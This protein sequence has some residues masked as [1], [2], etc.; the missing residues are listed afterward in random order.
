M[1][2]KIRSASV[3]GMEA[4]PVEI[5]VDLGPGVQDFHV[6]GMPGLAVKE[7]RRRVKSA[8]VN[9]SEQWPNRSITANLAPGDLRKEGS[10]LDLP[11]AVGVLAASGQLK[12]RNLD[13]YLMVG[14]L[15]LD[16]R[17]R[18]VRGALAAALTARSTGA[19]GVVLP[20]E[21]ALEAALVPGIEVMGAQHLV[22][23]LSFLRGDLTLP[24]RPPS[25]ASGNSTSSL[26]LSDV[27]GQALAKRAL[28]IA[29]AGSHNLLMVGPPGCGKTMLA[30]RLPGILPPMSQ[31]ECLEVTHVWSVA[32]LLSERN[33]IVTE[34]PFRS[35]HHHASAA[36]VI[37]GGSP[38]PRPGEASLAHHGVLFLDELPLFNRAVLEGLREPLQEGE[39]TIARMGSTLRFP[40]AASLVAA[41]NPCPCGR[42]GEKR[43]TC[44]CPASRIEAYRSRL[45]GPFL[46]RID[47]HA[48]VSR[49]SEDELFEMDPS[50]SSASVRMRVAAARQRRQSRG[51]CSPRE[52]LEP[53]AERVL[54]RMFSAQG[55]SARS[56]DRSLRVALTIA[57]LAASETI[58]EDHVL[59]ALQFR[60]VVWTEL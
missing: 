22:E 29:A 9:S 60:R 39:V 19:Q 3:V 40:A 24:P 13:R 58:E 6:V 45:S 37:G 2:A 35:P 26:D 21:N 49:L 4:Q 57:D 52:L 30:R 36:S 43:A 27:K 41:A 28:E 14:E 34:R 11:L 59:E 33:P 32:G 46:D 1:L 25:S 44:T 16:G 17:L 12:G 20:E 7:S 47:V 23:A 38:W 8:I 18:P 31:D 5:E 51:G 53:D 50:E 10:L 54:R 48:E 56:F 15:A 42:F 55:D